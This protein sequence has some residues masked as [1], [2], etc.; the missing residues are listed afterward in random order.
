MENLVYE[1][2]DT[3]L[4]IARKV[5]G[6]F[7]KYLI[8]NDEAIGEVASAIAEAD[9]DWNPDYRSPDNKVRSLRSLRNQRGIWAIQR[10]LKKN[11]STN[12]H[13]ISL[14]YTANDRN[15]TQTPLSGTIEDH[16]IPN[17][18]DILIEHETKTN[19]TSLL[20]NVLTSGIISKIQERYIR[21]Y[22]LEEKTLK[23]V[24]ETY[25]VSRQ[26]VQEAINLGLSSIRKYL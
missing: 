22:Y 19:Q 17:P 3:Y 4:A 13:T 11:K 24:G 20:D 5:I 8:T 26:T 15:T 12:P 9:K 10:Y 6:R 23:E 7:A 2:L 21:A 25:G 1:N 18:C 16:R 14:S